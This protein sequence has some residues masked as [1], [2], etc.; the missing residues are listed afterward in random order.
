MYRYTETQIY[1]EKLSPTSRRFLDKQKQIKSQKQKTI[2][3]SKFRKI[4]ENSTQL[5]PRFE[6]VTL[7]QKYSP[8]AAVQHEPLQ[9]KKITQKERRKNKPTYHKFYLLTAEGVLVNIPACPPLQR[10]YINSNSNVKQPH[11]HM[12]PRRRNRTNIYIK[13]ARGESRKIGKVKSWS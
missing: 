13:R 8:S 10:M 11:E 9:N 7:K 3:T 12:K 4:S 1:H 6:Q 5:P 2:H